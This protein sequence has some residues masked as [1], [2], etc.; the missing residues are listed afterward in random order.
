MPVL[1]EELALKAFTLEGCFDSSDPLKDYGPND[2]QSS[3]ACQEQ[4]VRLGKAVMG[5]TKGT[6][7]W[8]GDLI[9]AA[10]SKVSDSKCNSFC[11][12]FDKE[13]CRSGTIVETPTTVLT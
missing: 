8:C 1:A 6:N 13:M 4:C 9:P 11:V 12:G 5:L 3:G 10:D 2:F 7:C